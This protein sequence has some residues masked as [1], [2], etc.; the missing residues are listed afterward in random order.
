MKFCSKCNNMFYIRIFNQDEDEAN[1]LIY[2]CRNCGNEEKMYDEEN[3]NILTTEFKKVKQ[4][5]HNY[6]NEYTIYD[7]TLP[8]VSH[9]PCPNENCPSYIEEEKPNDVIYIRYNTTDMKYVY[10]CVYC[11]HI[12]QN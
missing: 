6:I 8:H 9:I 3:L 12:W 1:T 5:F 7:P 4:S 2:Y 10:M 11:R